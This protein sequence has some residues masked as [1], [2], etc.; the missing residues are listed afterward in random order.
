MKYLNALYVLE[1]FKMLFCAHHVQ[2]YAA[3]T[4]LENG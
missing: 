4:V 2:N 3:E 1:K